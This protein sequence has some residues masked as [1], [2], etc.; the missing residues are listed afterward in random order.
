[1]EA[2]TNEWIRKA[3]LQKQKRKLQP[4]SPKGQQNAPETPQ[5]PT[6]GGS[7]DQGNK[8]TRKRITGPVNTVKKKNI[9]DRL[10][11]PLKKLVFSSNPGT[12]QWNRQTEEQV[13]EE[14]PEEEPEEGIE[15]GDPKNMSQQELI[16]EVIRLRKSREPADDSKEEQ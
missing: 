10:G 11:P 3:R 2:S 15:P 4:K 14:E 6:P 16:E 8:I 13:P 9:K 5:T 12:T 1:M 7:T